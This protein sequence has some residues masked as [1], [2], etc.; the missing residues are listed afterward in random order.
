MADLDARLVARSD[1]VHAHLT[2]LVG[3]TR[4]HHAACEA[5]HLGACVG[6]HVWEELRRLSRHEV[7]E[8]LGVALGQLST[9]HAPTAGPERTPA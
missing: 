4:T 3:R 8:L 9:Q 7:V 6:P 2:T 5:R 1:Q